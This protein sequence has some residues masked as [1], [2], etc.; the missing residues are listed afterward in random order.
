[1][2][3]GLFEAVGRSGLDRVRLLEPGASAGLNLL[4]DQFRIGGD[5]WWAGGADSPLVLADAVHGAV[6]PVDYQ[7]V[8]RRG[9]DLEPVDATTGQ[10]RRRLTSFVWP[11]Q[12]QRHDRLRAALQIAA[13]HPIDIDQ[14]RVPGIGLQS[15][16][17]CRLS[18]VC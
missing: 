10:G 3:V 4:V 11:Y 16:S 7:I 9:C 2:L 12:T 1:L 18:L 8:E 14:M 15:N 5:G 6:E 13:S 17:R